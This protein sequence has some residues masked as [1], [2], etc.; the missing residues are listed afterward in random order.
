MKITDLI[1]GEETAFSFEILPPLKGAGMGKLRETID[2]LR[3]FNPRYMN[4][5]THHSIPVYRD[6]GGGLLQRAMLRKRPG[7]VAVA[8]AL[9]QAY[10][11]PMVPHILCS[12]Y[13]KEETEY[14]LIDLQYL[15][16]TNL[17][18]LR[19]DGAREYEQANPGVQSYHHT[20]ELQQQV[21][22]YN[23]GYFVDG[24][25]IN[26]PGEPFSYGVACYPEKHEEA[27]N[28]STDLHWFA[29]KV[30]L[31]AEY[32]VTQMFYDN[33]K[34]FRFV[35]DCRQAGIEVPIIPGIKPLVKLKQLTS[36]PRIFHMDLPEA[37]T[38]E[39][40]KCKTDEEM[41]RVG[42]EWCVQQCRGLMRRGV[43]SIHFYTT[44]ASDAVAEVARQI[45]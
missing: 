2:R 24:T 23:E 31:G 39:A 43:P 41:R 25:R 28:M 19:G 6:A 44:G 22:R 37:F 26:D 1:K 21:N 33:D 7:T 35:D 16:I 20:T 42:I 8:A 9:Q 38:H 12:G 29:E 15:G 36:L 18:L 17:L 13:S 30:R 11:I 40:L 14:V 27:P 5:T 32:G 4:I 3:D 45:Y 10:G 34:Y